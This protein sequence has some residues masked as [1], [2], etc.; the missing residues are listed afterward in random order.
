MNTIPIKIGSLELLEIDYLHQLFGLTERVALKWLRTLEITTLHISNKAYFSAEALEITLRVIAESGQAFSMPGSTKK[1]Q[2]HCRGLTNLTSEMK[3]RI[4]NVQTQTTNTLNE[5]MK[6]WQEQK[7]E[8]KQA[9]KVLRDLRKT[10]KNKKHKVPFL[11]KK[12]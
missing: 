2:L 6:L 8:I 5:R 10:I 9:K 12:A 3:K 7:T 11:Q 1:N 4:C